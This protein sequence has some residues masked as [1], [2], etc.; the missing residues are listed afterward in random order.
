MASDKN[1]DLIFSACMSK[2]LF[3]CVI[4][5]FK[6]DMKSLI[7][8]TPRHTCAGV[9]IGS[10]SVLFS[11]RVQTLHSLGPSQA[12]HPQ[13]EP[14]APVAPTLSPDRPALRLMLIAPT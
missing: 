11:F 4:Y 14:S 13:A 3:K 10:P 7:S 2:L 5:F 9:L 1:K 8:E 12:A 6:G